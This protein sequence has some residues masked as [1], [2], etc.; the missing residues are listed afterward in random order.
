MGET[1]AWQP[2]DKLKKNIDTTAMQDE[3]MMIHVDN[4]KKGRGSFDVPLG[5]ILPVITEMAT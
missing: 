5:C 4:L 3:M 2:T 1:K